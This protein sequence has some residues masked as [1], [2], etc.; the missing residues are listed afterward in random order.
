MWEQLNLAAFVQK[1]W[2]DNGVSITVTFN[3]NE[4]KDIENALNMFQF[5]LKAVSFLPHTKKNIYK[6]M[7]YEEI[8]KEQY[9]E[10]T[11]KLKPLNFSKMFSEEAIGEKYCNNDICSL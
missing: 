3:K 6:Q 10:M 9:E 7:P 1:N 5:Q 8:T 4:E 2:S 11:S